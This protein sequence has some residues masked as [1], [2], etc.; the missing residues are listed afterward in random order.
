MDPKGK[1]QGHAVMRE[2]RGLV[3]GAQAHIA[4]VEVAA[5]PAETV[6]TFK[7]EV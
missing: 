5:K 4:S 6:E 1:D 2:L 3:G 7:R